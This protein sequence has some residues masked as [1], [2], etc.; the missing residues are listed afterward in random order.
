ML[1]AEQ[2]N[3]K[4]M[5]FGLGDHAFAGIGQQNGQVGGG[6]TGNHVAGIL[7][8]TRCISNDKLPFGR[9]EIAV[10]HINGDPLFTFGFQS[11]EQQ[12][13]IDLLTGMSHAFAVAFQCGE[14]VFVQFFTIEKQ[15]S[16]E[17]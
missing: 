6:T 12:R 15:P 8:V 17:G 7:L 3:Q 14:L 4:S 11:V 13:V 1:Y 9:G 2:R 5:P 10:S 16:D